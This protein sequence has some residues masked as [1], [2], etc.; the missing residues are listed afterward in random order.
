MLYKI[1]EIKFDN[2]LDFSI[3]EQNDEYKNDYNDD[4]EYDI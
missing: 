1:K 4:D 3:S 2:E